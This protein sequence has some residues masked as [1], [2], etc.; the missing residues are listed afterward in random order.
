MTNQRERDFET[1]A[2][3]SLL[4][5][6]FTARFEACYGSTGTAGEKT[7][8]MKGLISDGEGE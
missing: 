4:S 1:F 5:L 7:I 8:S 6:M 2:S 3:R